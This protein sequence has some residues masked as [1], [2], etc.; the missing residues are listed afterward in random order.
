V[1]AKGECASGATTCGGRSQNVCQS[2]EYCAFT[3][4][5]IC[6][7]ADATGTCQ[8][9]PDGCTTQYAP[10]C[11]CDGKTY[12][13]DCEANRAGTSVQSEGACAGDGA[14]CGG[15]QGLT[16]GAGQFCNFDAAN[17]GSGDQTGTCQA[18]PD[19]CPQVESPVCGCDGVQYGNSCFANA[20]GVAVSN[21]TS[22]ETPGATCGGLRGSMCPADQY[23]D[24]P[25]ATKCG[26]GDQ[27][28]SCKA[29]HVVCPQVTGPTLEVCGC[30][31]KTYG[32]SC[33][34]QQ[35]GVSVASNGACQ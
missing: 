29:M 25:S 18:I 20:A 32:S 22:C 4:D 16:C 2:G 14:T 10:V 24:F 33:F 9:K 21:D 15:L 13:N 3:L 26:S 6:G 11:G 12:G 8:P 34:A 19:L 30:D 27:T 17:C 7:F 35:A 31:G 5:A 28:G 23:C 1:A